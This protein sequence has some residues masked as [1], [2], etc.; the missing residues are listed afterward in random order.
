MWEAAEN[1]TVRSLNLNSRAVLQVALFLFF[2]AGSSNVLVLSYIHDFVPEGKPLPDV[3]F[4]NTPYLPKL[5]KVSEYLMISSFAGML[6]LT[7]LHRHRWIV[8]R[9][10]ATIGSLLYFG[11]CVTMFVTQVPVADPNYYCAPKLS[12]SVVLRGC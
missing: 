7:L 5:L 6:L 1:R 2:V 9:R 12:V 10:I 3:V 4:D 11:R 8:L